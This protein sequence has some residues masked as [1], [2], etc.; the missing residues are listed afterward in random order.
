MDKKSL[1][2]SAP[3]NKGALLCGWKSRSVRCQPHHRNKLN[4][5]RPTLLCG[6]K[7]KHQFIDMVRFRMLLRCRRTY[8]AVQEQCVNV[9]EPALPGRENCRYAVQP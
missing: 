4:S 3:R 2:H 9:G 7:A 6:R 8:H 1:S 5:S